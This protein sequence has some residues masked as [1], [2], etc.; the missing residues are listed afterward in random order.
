MCAVIRRTGGLEV[1]DVAAGSEAAVIRRTGGLEVY[2]FF[3]C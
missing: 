2:G 1:I 3:F